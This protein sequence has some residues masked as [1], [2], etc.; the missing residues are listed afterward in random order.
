MTCIVKGKYDIKTGVNVRNGII[1]HASVSTKFQTLCVRN[2]YPVDDSMA[3]F[4]I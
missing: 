1:Q 2:K 3:L 4:V